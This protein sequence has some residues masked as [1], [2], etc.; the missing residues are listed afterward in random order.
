MKTESL[1]TIFKSAQR[2]AEETSTYKCFYTF[3]SS[4]H[5]NELKTSFGP[6]KFLNEELLSPQGS[7]TYTAEENSQI[8]LLPIAGALNYSNSNQDEILVK[9]EQ[10]KILETGKTL[11]YTVNNPFEQEWIHYLHIGFNTGK[12]HSA[13]QSLLQDIE[14]KK[15]NELVCFNSAQQTDH[16]GYIGI[17]EG[18]SEGT[19]TIKKAGNGI[20]VYVI[21]GAF[22]VQGRLLEQK[23]GLSLWDIEKIEFE[24]LSSNAIILLLEVQLKLK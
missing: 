23:D 14:F 19:Y 3:N 22:E 15:M 17:Y 5:Q 20:F 21:K 7:I 8:I 12:T 13:A 6:L 10:I 1:A 18:R 11:S 16:L 4:N 9:S 24:A 2:E